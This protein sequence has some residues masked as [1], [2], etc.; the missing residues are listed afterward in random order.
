MLAT[1]STSA[2]VS[3]RPVAG[4]TMASRSGW[5]SALFSSRL[6]RLYVVTRST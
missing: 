3:R 6:E 5:A 1:V 4:K 2:Y